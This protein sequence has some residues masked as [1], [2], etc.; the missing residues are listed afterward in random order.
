MTQ[1]SLFCVSCNCYV[2]FA[3]QKL[4]KKNFFFTCQC[5]TLSVIPYL[6]FFLF[7]FTQ[8]LFVFGIVSVKELALGGN[9]NVPVDRLKWMTDGK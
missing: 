8:D 7:V 5:I 6:H 4:K 3:C 9:T 1:C 2:V